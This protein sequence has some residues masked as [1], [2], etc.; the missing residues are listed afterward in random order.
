VLRKLN[1]ESD[2]LADLDSNCMA[3]VPNV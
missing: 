3:V 2:W 1:T